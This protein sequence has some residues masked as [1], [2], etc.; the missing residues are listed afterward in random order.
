[1][2]KWW[3]T[4]FT[5]YP[6]D[7][8][9]LLHANVEKGDDLKEFRYILAA[10]LSNESQLVGCGLWKWQKKIPPLKNVDRIVI[11]AR[12]LLFNDEC[13]YLQPHCPFAVALSAWRS[14]GR[15]GPAGEPSRCRPAINGHSPSTTALKM[16]KKTKSF[17]LNFCLRQKTF[18]KRKNPFSLD[19]RA[20]LQPTSSAVSMSSPPQDT[21]SLPIS[22][23]RVNRPAFE[24]LGL[25]AFWGKECETGRKFG[26]FARGGLTATNSFYRHRSG[27][28]QEI[29]TACV[30]E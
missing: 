21:P 13:L 3:S 26:S 6:F 10:L 2:K 9:V 8:V 30:I 1:M 23:R 4:R 27:K 12:Y 22:R 29:N 11:Y 14:L 7:N 24:W 25:I 16:N 18:P 15:C 19:V 20:S 17:S 5:A 28:L